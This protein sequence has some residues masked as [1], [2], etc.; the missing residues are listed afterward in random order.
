MGK[1]VKSSRAPRQVPGAFTAAELAAAEAADQR[2]KTATPKAVRHAFFPEAIAIGKLPLRPL[3]LGD[4]LFLEE[5]GS[6]LIAVPEGDKAPE[7]GLRD[8]LRAIFLLA[9]TPEKVWALLAKGTP[10]FDH[11]VNLFAHRIPYEEITQVGHKL[12]ALIDA[13][14]ATVQPMSGEKKTSGQTPA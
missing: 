5:I 4:F 2:G 7:V 10:C 12:R 11:E 3:S 13:A 9:E 14:F 8:Y 1:K 6:P